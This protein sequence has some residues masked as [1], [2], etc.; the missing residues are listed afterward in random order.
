MYIKSNWRIRE[1]SIYMANQA[2]HNKTSFCVGDT[3]KVYQTIKEGEKERQQVFEGIVI[4]IKGSKENKSFCARKIAIGGIGVERIWPVQSPWIK[5][6]EVV[7]KGKVK[8]AKLY[9]LRDRVGKRAVRVK[10]QEMPKKVKAGKVKKAAKAGKANDKTEEKPREN[11]R[12]AG[13]K[14]S[15]K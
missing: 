11:R 7:K 14:T 5:K 10:E 12:T 8:R 15:S 9:Y 3:I 6:L 4:K 2:I 13:K 1:Y